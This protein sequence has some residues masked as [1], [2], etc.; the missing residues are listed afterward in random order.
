MSRIRGVRFASTSPDID[1][2]NIV[3]P[4]VSL[5]LA[6]GGVAGYAMFQEPTLKNASLG[7]AIVGMALYTKSYFGANARGG[8]SPQLM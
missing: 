8:S 7:A 4:H 3:S 2:G 6:V 5:G 1:D